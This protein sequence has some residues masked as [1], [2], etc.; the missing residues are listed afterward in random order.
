[1]TYKKS[2]LALLIASTVAL[3]GCLDDNYDYSS[4][5]GGNSGTGSNKLTAQ[6]PL[7]H[8]D[9]KTHTSPY[10][11]TAVD[12]N[13]M[14]GDVDG[15][16]N[17]SLEN[18]QVTGNF[19]DVEP[20]TVEISEDKASLIFKANKEYDITAANNSADDQG[21]T[22]QFYVETSH[23]E[24]GEG[25]E[26][27][28]VMLTMGNGEQSY[29]IDISS[30]MAAA[31]VTETG[32][33]Q[34]IRV[35]MSCFIDQGLDLTTVDHAMGIESEGAIEYKISQARLASNSV[36]EVI[37]TNNIQGCLNNNNSEIL[38][39]NITVLNRDTRTDGNWV[40]QGKTDDVRIMRGTSIQPNPG[41]W[42]NGG[43][44]EGAIRFRGIEYD[45]KFDTKRRSTLTFV[46]DGELGDM[47]Q[48]R[49]D[50]S[51]YYDKGELQMA[52]F[53]PGGTPIPSGDLK[54]VVS[55]D[56]PSVNTGGEPTPGLP[57]GGYGN[58][59]TVSYNLTEAG[60]TDAT[61]HHVSIPLRELFTKTNANT[62][63]ETVSL[64][65]LQYVE[66]IVTHIEQ[67]DANGD[68][69]FSNLAGFKYGLADIK[70]VMNPSDDEPAPV[71]K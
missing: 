25:P 44:H 57:A 53:I 31:A 5:G 58:S 2:S 22:V 50:M 30:A 34:W 43:S 68:A 8:D 24:I 27:N 54:L 16:E 52:F 60:V 56:S 23:Y 64:N 3:T 41:S 7:Y 37:G 29:G 48:P 26:R 42:E 65:A 35:P 63:A 28:K 32:T 46:I 49:L 9:P 40:I 51:H 71:A 15:Q 36:P 38:T 67:T 21:G 11:M 45:E 66:K 10:I 1:M 6:V 33:A 59:E 19:L 20:L 69:D 47:N 61:V 4:G 18:I 39:D 12:V 70:I 17:A 55:M 62:G 14:E 13:G